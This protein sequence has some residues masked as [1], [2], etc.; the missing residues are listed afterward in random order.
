MSIKLYFLSSEEVRKIRKQ[1]DVDDIVEQLKVMKIGNRIFYIVEC[2]VDQNGND[3]VPDF[4][5]PNEET[6][7]MFVEKAIA[8]Y[9]V[10][11]Q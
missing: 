9:V 6:F 4:I 1:N 3:I 10:V 8:F 7:K 11:S 2:D 5:F